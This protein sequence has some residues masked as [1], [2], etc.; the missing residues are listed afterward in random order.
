[1]SVV[2][3]KVISLA[4]KSAPV[5]NNN[6]SRHSRRI[7]PNHSLDKRMRPGNIGYCFDFSYTE[8]SQIRFPLM[9]PIQRI[10]IG[11]EI[12]WKSC[13]ASD[14]LLEHATQRL[15]VDNAGMD[16]ESDDSTSV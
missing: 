1:M 9:K 10:V 8:D 2:L 12:P 15:T 11:T 14:S 4:S 13:H 5:Q 7:V 16:S 6:Y 3:L